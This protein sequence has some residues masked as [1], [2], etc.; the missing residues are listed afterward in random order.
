MYWYIPY[1]HITQKKPAIFR[2]LVYLV[3]PASVT[4][5]KQDT[6]YIVYS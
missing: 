3:L 4:L 6:L 5:T 2:D 1:Q